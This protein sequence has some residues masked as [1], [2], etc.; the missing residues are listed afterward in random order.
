MR[1]FLL[2]CAATLSLAVTTAHGP[3]VRFGIVAFDLRGPVPDKLSELG[4]GLVR[5]SCQ[6]GDLEPARGVFRWDCADNVIVGAQAADLRAYMTV[7]CTPAWAN[8][9]SGCAQMPDDVTDWYVFVAQ[10]V[11]RYENYRPILG[12]WNEPNLTL[13]DRPDGRGYALL[14]VN[15]SR[16]RAA[17]DPAFTLA[18]PET[19]HHALAS[20]YYEHAM[21]AIEGA[22]AL[23]PQDIVGVHWY[24]DGPPID[25]YLNAIHA[26]AGRQDVWLSE[27][28]YATADASAQAAFYDQMLERFLSPTRPS[29]W[30]HV[31]FYRLWDGHD[32]C[33][34]A[35]LTSDY[36]NKPAFDMYRRRIEAASRT[37]IAPTRD[38][39]SAGAP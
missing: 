20:G 33:T 24:S 5:G 35:I 32:C 7:T 25:D 31:V 23:A 19:S 1:F 11:A 4:V 9:G 18:G 28:G 13:S 16:A 30:T 17:V 15:A 29:W 10:F 39:A 26:V 21:D 6:W 36:R 38:A 12:V 3:R 22:G 2:L 27:T 37:L 14:Y 34:D 8:G